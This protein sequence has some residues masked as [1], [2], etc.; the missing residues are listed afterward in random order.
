MLAAEYNEEPKCDTC[1]PDLKSENQIP[2]EIWNMVKYQWIMGPQGAVD[3]QIQ[4]IIELI[5]MY[6]VP[7]NEK[8][9]CLNL[10]SNASRYVL[11][12]LKERDKQ[13]SNKEGAPNG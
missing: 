13:Q 8:V 1:M 9:Y 11:Y 12:R 7:D 5:N 2:Y 3:I 10:V 4:P 6:Q